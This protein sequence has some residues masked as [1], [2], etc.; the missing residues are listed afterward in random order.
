MSAGHRDKRLNGGLANQDLND[1]IKVSGISAARGTEV[2][3]G[4]EVM[5]T[6]ARNRATEAPASLISA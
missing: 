2:E 6:L 1:A 3:E 5:E 4:E